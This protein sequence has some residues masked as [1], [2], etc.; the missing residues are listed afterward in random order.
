MM[1]G[2]ENELKIDTDIILGNVRPEYLNY[3]LG[4]FKLMPSDNR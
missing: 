2:G 1:C 3:R 4:G